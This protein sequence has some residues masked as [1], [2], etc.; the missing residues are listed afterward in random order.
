MTLVWIWVII[1][2][3]IA[4]LIGSIP[5]SYIFTKLFSGKDL[6][7]VGTKNVGGLNTMVTTNFTIGIFAGLMDF[8]KALICVLTV[9]IINFDQ[10][11]LFGEGKYYELT[12]HRLII[13]LVATFVVAGHNFSIYLGF[14]GGRGLGSSAGILSLI[15]PLILFVHLIGTALWTFT[16]KYVR[17][18][19]FLAFAL[20]LPAAFLIP[21][22]PP[23]IVM[24][25]FDTGFSVGLLVIG[26]AIVTLPK[27]VKPLFDM[28]K[29]KEYKI[30][31]KELTEEETN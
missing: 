21:I 6:R 1:C 30:G 15:N 2:P 19:Q 26:L 28:F 5:F 7:K 20:T 22:Y 29:G 16:T 4:Y 24:Q 23:W 14:K 11:V 10:S 27:Y 12:W 17:P 9:L 31:K 3:L 8:L 25:N 13:I 18:S